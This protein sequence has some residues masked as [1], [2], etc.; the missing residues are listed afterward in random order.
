MKLLIDRELFVRWYFDEDIKK[1]FV[2]N[3]SVIED[4]VS[5]GVF[6]VTAQSLLDEVG[7]IP[8]SIVSEHQEN[9]VLDEQGEVDMDAYTK[10][11]FY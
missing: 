8:M 10:I 3:K 11:K 7:Y 6:K 4:L 9:V 5:D 1:D 2:Y